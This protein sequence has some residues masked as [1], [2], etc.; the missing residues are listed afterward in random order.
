MKLSRIIQ[1]VNSNLAEEM[2]P[3]SR[4]KDLCDD[5]IDNI[6]SKLCSKFPSMSDFCDAHTDTEGVIDTTADYNY[7]PDEYIRQVLCKGAAYKYYVV[8]EEGNIASAMYGYNYRD[9][10]FNM[11]RDWIEQVPA[12]YQD[13]TKS[14]AATMTDNLNPKTNPVQLDIWSW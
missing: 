5:V 9:E 6:N 4:I 1:K 14:G 13:N 10:L 11:E 7:F 12:E 8:D 3:I 2:L